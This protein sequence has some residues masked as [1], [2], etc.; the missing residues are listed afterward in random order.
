MDVLILVRNL[1]EEERRDIIKALEDL[2]T[3]VFIDDPEI[4]DKAENAIAALVSTARHPRVKGILTRARNLKF[5]QTLAAGV[6][7][8]PFKDLP[9]NIVVASNSGA[10]AEE[11]AE[12]TVALILASMKNIVALDRGM[13][14]GIWWGPTPRLIKGSKIVIVGYG[15]IGR[16][17]AK[18]LRPFDPYIIGVSRNPV[19]DKYIDE[20]VKADNL[21]EVL[22]VADIVV[23]TLPLTKNTY[24]LFDEKKLNLLKKGA[25]I[26]NI[27]RGDVVDEDALFRRLSEGDMSA[28]LDVWWVYP[29]ARG[30]PTFQ[31]K[32]FHLIENLVMTPHTAGSWPGFRRKL[33]NNALENM[34]RFLVGETPRN[35]VA[36]EEYI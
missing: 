33:I 8:I 29:K 36:R 31:N 1:T 20:A 14:N 22:P 19:K 21:E 24:R 35:I 7:N 30:E 28:A 12:F 34:R 18:R 5:I 11:V 32:P 26:V 17:V 6:D 16:E 2:A 25:L 3:P 9:E 4:D 27:G 15:N 13:R 23:V 10:N